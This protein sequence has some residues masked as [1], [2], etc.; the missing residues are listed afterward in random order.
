MIFSDA[1]QKESLLLYYALTRQQKMLSASKSKVDPTAIVVS[2]ASTLAAWHGLTSSNEIEFSIRQIILFLM[3]Q[4]LVARDR[5]S[6]TNI[7]A[8]LKVKP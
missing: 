2:V 3:R 6:Y 4:P 1:M 5:A 7:R 8:Q